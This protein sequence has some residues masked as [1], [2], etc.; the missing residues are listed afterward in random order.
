MSCA[1]IAVAFLFSWTE[2]KKKLLLLTYWLADGRVWQTTSRA[3]WRILSPRDETGLRGAGEKSLRAADVMSNFNNG[4]GEN[5]Q[6]LVSSTVGREKKL[7]QCGK[8]FPG[9]FLQRLWLVFVVNFRCEIDLIGNFVARDNR[10]GGEVVTLGINSQKKV[11]IDIF[12]L[13][14]VQKLR[15]HC[16]MS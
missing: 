8:C 13:E 2:K 10:G 15:K 11:F 9:G 7:C 3:R 4:L 1:E 12:V 14:Y 5:N 6:L 16:R